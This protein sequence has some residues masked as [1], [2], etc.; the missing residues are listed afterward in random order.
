[1]SPNQNN[2]NELKESF[3][4][5]VQ[6]NYEVQDYVNSALR[7]EDYAKAVRAIDNYIKLIDDFINQADKMAQKYKYNGNDENASI[8]F[9]AEKMARHIKT[10]H[11]EVEENI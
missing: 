5:L 8:C 10:A 7:L 9:K 3:D 1:M 6:R 2:I 4:C 11:L